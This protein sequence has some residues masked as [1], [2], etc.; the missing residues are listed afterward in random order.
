M[1][2]QVAQGSVLSPFLFML[3]MW[4]IVETLEDGVYMIIYA[5]DILLYVIDLD[6]DRARRKI[7]DTLARISQW[8]MNYPMNCPSLLQSVR[9]S[10]SV[11]DVTLVFSSRFKE[12][13]FLGIPN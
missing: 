10:T 5:D 1:G 6:E 3:Y 12:R 8:L 2:A 11:D 13:K 4:D 9:Q 7:Q